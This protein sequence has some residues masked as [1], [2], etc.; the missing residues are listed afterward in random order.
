M[1]T[2]HRV[3]VLVAAIALAAV[4]CT[5]GGG[6]SSAVQTIN[7]TAS[8]SPVT[9]TFWTFFADP[10]IQH[11][12]T[13]IDAF[14]QQ[15]PWI[16]VNVVPNK[17]DTAVFQ[18]INSGSAPDVTMV[19]VPDDSAKLC[20]TNAWIDLNP[21]IQADKIDIKSLVPSGALVYTGYKGNQCSLPVLTDAYGLYYNTDLFQS[22]GITSPPKTYS[23]LFEDM[24]KL[25]QFNAD[26]SIKV[27]GFLPLATGDYELANYLNGVYSDTHWY[28]ADG[29]SALASDPKFAQMLTTF[30]QMT[31]WIGYDK[32]SRFFAANGGEDGEF[33]PSNLFENGKLAMDFD[34]EWRVGFI[35]DDKSTVNYATAPAPVADDQP[36]LY[37]TGQIGGSTIGIPRGGKHLAE[38]WLLVKYLSLNPD[39]EKALAEALH[40]VPSVNSALDDPVLTGDP[41]FK[42]FLD[43]FKNPNSRYKEVTTLGI[44]DVDSFDQFVDKY[45]AGKVSDLQAG[46]Q[47]VATNIDQQ[48]ALG[49]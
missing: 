12:R 21:Y 19:G 7:P 9:I 41:H 1:R 25:T 45:L 28:D 20:S 15:Y 13:A 35:K 2:R 31:D 30:K 40:N 42:T 36:Q 34:G 11:F 44:Q 4:G 48:L 43:I 27:A 38:A 18:A 24:K 26:G 32:L 39:A 3:V 46:L 37:G 29:K 33:N 5:A 23:E 14:H 10:E 8:H 6:G 17:D 49:Q 22:A 16:T 47:Q